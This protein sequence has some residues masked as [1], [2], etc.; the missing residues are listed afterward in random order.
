MYSYP[1]GFRNNNLLNI[2]FLLEFSYEY[3]LPVIGIVDTSASR[4]YISEE[5]VPQ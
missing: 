3:K 4:N 2:E 5:I 1:I